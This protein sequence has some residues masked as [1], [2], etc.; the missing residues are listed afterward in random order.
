MDDTH[1]NDDLVDCFLQ[2]TTLM[3]QFC[4]EIRKWWNR[5]KKKKR[6]SWKRTCSRYYA[7]GNKARLA[8]SC[9]KRLRIRVTCLTSSTI[10]R[11]H[12]DLHEKSH[13][14]GIYTL[15][16][17][18]LTNDMGDIIKGTGSEVQANVTGIGGRK[19]STITYVGAGT[20]RIIDD[21]GQTCELPVPELYYC[22]TVPYR[23][24]I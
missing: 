10:N 4:E 22:P 18:F 19:S 12:D 1:R 20:F 16:T 3:K 5:P 8:R 11:K 24:I 9:W 13:S 23:I 2:S 7:W 6:K 17:Y 14:L 15:S 21:T